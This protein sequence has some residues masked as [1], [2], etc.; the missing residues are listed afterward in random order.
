MEQQPHCGSQAVQAA[1]ATLPKAGLSAL[2]SPRV[3]EKTYRGRRGRDGSPEVWVEEFRPAAVR[4]RD[5]TSMRPL[6]LHLEVRGH[7]PTGFAWGYGGS[8]PAQLALALLTDATGDEDLA[9]RHYQELRRQFVAWWKDDWSI[10][11]REVR[12]FV[13]NQK[14]PHRQSGR[15]WF[16]VDKQGLA[17]ILARKGKEF[18]LFELIQNAWDEPGVTQVQV[19][20]ERLGRNL[21]CLVVEDDAPEGFK[22]LSHA[23]TLF[24]DSAKKANPEQRGRFNLG[25]KLVLAISD[26]VTIRT[27]SGGLRFDAAGRHTLRA[28]QPKGSR[29]ECVVRMTAEQCQEIEAQVRKLISPER[30]LTVFNRV[31]LEPRRPLKQFKTTLPTELATEDGCLRRVNRETTLCLYDVAPDET[32]MLYEMGIPVVETGDK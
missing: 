4:R 16:E 14:Q 6:P 18:A 13:A 7:S 17:R 15:N 23:F 3:A 19:T 1:G 12:A 10:T 27:A 21:A 31:P 30:I 32:A 9:L 2:T 25:E 5:A 11:A 8:G 22:D 20:L 29:I 26:E 28:G 24:A